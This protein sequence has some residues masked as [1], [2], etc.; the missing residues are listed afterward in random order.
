MAT[1][2]ANYFTGAA[3]HTPRGVDS[4]PPLATVL[5]DIADDLGGIKVAA[6]TEPAASDLSTVIALANE[7]R[8]NLLA[9]SAV[10]LKTVKG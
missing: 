9:V 1:I 7:I 10:T 8:T 5:R 6:L 2:K 4:Q 3:G